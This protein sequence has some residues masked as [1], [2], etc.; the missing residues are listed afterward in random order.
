MRRL[1]EYAHLAQR[2]LWHL[3]ATM[4]SLADWK[5]RSAVRI[6]RADP[7]RY[8]L[9]IVLLFAP[10]IAQEFTVSVLHVENSVQFTIQMQDDLILAIEQG[11]AEAA[12]CTAPTW[13][14][15][16]ATDSERVCHVLR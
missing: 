2:S 11:D 5:R 15:S 12:I 13:G 10:F 1:R 14:P 9:R 16:S 3:E 7:V 6:R 4:R 8:D